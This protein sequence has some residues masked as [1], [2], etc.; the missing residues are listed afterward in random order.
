MLHRFIFLIG[1]RT[2][3][4]PLLHGRVSQ[5][6]QRLIT[7]A[8]SYTHLDVYKRQRQETAGEDVM[9]DEIHFVPVLRV[10]LIGD[11]NCLQQHHAVRLEQLG[12]GA[13]IGCLLYT[14]R[15]V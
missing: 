10:L 13:E 9:P 4:L 5:Q 2:K 6:A 11:G 14:S 1:N 8:V 12:A 7:V 15:C 3:N